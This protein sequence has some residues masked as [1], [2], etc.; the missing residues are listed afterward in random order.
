M[1][2]QYI[3]FVEDEKFNHELFSYA[4]QDWNSAHF[5]EGKEF[6]PEIAT[7]YEDA[8]TAL[9]RFKIDCALLDL[10][11][12]EKSEGGKENPIIGNK[13][14]NEVLFIQGL[15][16]AIL[17][18]HPDEVDESLTEGDLVRTFNKG[19]KD[20]F[21][22]ALAWLADKWEMMETLR[23][24]KNG[25]DQMSATVFANRLWPRW[26]TFSKLE[27]GKE[28]LIKIISRQYVGHVADIMGLDSELGVGWHPFESYNI[29]SLFNDRAH[30]GDIFEI[31]GE[32]FL[33]L[34]PQ[35][36]MANQ[37]ITNVILAK[38]ARG[39]SN[40]DENL[41][42]LKDPPSQTKKDRSSKFFSD[43]VNQNLPASMHFLPP[44]PGTQ[45]PLLVTFSDLQTVP[46]G[47][48]NKELGSRVASVSN[49]FISNLVQR[50]GAYVS[51]T[52]QP[53][54]EINHFT[55]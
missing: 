16:L 49:P 31:K 43:L 21:E 19:D 41:G 5:E 26:S 6:V 53:N 36:D 52:G 37:K 4:I 54:L 8:V 48:L 27:Q 15:P 34:T 28:K 55:N 32:L 11:L 10:R 40:W 24:A 39:I 25:I 18:G 38:C 42:I 33:V 46:L 51:R 44:L 47:D 50:F 13:L 7:S 45:E 20:G 14:A 9:A 12:P 30:T 2:R 3:L 22:Q 35:C 23:A 1:R 29:P 17:S